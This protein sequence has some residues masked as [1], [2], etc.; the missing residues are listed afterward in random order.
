MPLNFYRVLGKL[1][2]PRVGL[3]TTTFFNEP[4]APTADLAIAMEADADDGPDSGRGQDAKSKSGKGA[5][6]IK[7]EKESAPSTPIIFNP[8]KQKLK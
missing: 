7:K 2:R 1:M 5:K 6:L 3:S 4:E 8:K